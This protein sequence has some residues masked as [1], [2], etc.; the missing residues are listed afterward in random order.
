MKEKLQ[1][2]INEVKTLKQVEKV[3]K[4]NKIAYEVVEG[5]LGN[6]LKI[7]DINKYHRIVKMSNRLE[8]ITMVKCSIGGAEA[9]LKAQMIQD[10]LSF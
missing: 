5:F 2:L 10:K 1:Q 7:N 8:V 6:E 3:L 9:M 4:I